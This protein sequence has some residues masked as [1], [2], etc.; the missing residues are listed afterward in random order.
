MKNMVNYCDYQHK[1]RYMLQLLT[2]E[3]ATNI[4]NM[5]FENEIHVKNMINC[6]LG[7]VISMSVTTKQVNKINNYLK[8]V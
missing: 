5:E 2:I 7:E 4:I 6:D 1:Y 3:E 8:I